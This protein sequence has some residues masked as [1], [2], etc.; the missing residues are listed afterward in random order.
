MMDDKYVSISNIIATNQQLKK[1]ME[2]MGNLEKINRKRYMEKQKSK[3]RVV[4]DKKNREKER[5]NELADKVKMGI[6]HVNQ[7]IHVGFK[8]FDQI[9]KKLGGFNIKTRPKMGLKGKHFGTGPRFDPNQRERWERKVHRWNINETEKPID[10]TKDS[11]PGPHAYPQISHW[12]QKRNEKQKA[13]YFKIVS[14]GPK[15]SM[16]YK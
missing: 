6:N 12:N 1:E 5:L 7:P 14:K 4:K 10:P 2:K 8:T 9:A 13:N 16:Y 15:I 11:T 3:E